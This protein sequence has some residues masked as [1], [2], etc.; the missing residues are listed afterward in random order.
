MEASFDPHCS[1]KLVCDVYLACFKQ[2]SANDLVAT[3]CP[4]QSAWPSP[5][6]GLRPPA[7]GMQGRSGAAGQH[8]LPSSK[9]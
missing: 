4:W 8:R 5:M 7:V 1:T 6:F 2:H 9:L 3:R